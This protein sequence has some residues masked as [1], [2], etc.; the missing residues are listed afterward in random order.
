MN[1][2]CWSSEWQDRGTQSSDMETALFSCLQE[3]TAL[4]QFVVDLLSAESSEKGCRLKFECISN[5][6]I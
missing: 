2:L 5:H 6:G 3:R 1:D 4:L